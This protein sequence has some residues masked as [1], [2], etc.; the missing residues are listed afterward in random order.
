M[1]DSAI[2]RM[3]PSNDKIFSEL[4]EIVPDLVVLADPAGRLIIFNAACEELTGYRRHEVLGR[5]LM[6]VFVPASCAGVV[7]QRFA[8]PYSPDLRK[9]HENPWMTK[10]GEER[11]ISW[12]CTALKVAGDER[13]YILG[14]GT[15][16]TE[17]RLVEERMRA[18]SRLLE[19]FFESTL[20]CSVLLDRH[21]NFLRVNEAY[22]TACKR[23]AADFIGKNHFDLYPSPARAIFEKVVETRTFFVAHSHPFMFPDRPELGMTYWDWTLVPVLDDN[24]EIEVLLFCLN[25]VTER[26][27]TEAGLREA[28][29]E[30]RDMSRQIVETEERERRRIARELH[31]E[32]GQ[33][34]TAL[35]LVLEGAIGADDVAVRKRQRSAL[36]LSNE[37][38]HSIRQISFDLRPPVLD[39]LG[40]IPALVTMFE[41]FHAL[42]GLEV[43]FRHGGVAER[44]SQDVET[45][46]YRIVQ[47]ALTNVIR[48]AS[49]RLA[50]VSLWS[51]AETVLLRIEDQGAGFEPDAVRVGGG[52][53]LRGMRE[54][55][56]F[57]G[58]SLTVES[59]TGGGTII[60]AELP[61]QSGAWRA[62][63]EPLTS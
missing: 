27:R 48:H 7:G 4:L 16:V 24:G 21:F 6:E 22:A 3:L 13:P 18:Q 58:G 39:D 37:L 32:I 5:D 19:M 35:K 15:D 61:R 11:L 60:M 44:L 2:L 53:G 52:N 31:D 56:R 42:A 45:V 9:P 29:A 1:D 12:R 55:A 54:R 26:Q 40:L 62:P 57:L 46:A 38:L 20:T 50:S 36:D 8:D 14:I 30:L 17:K 47:E 10:S 34:L 59:S 41:R 25:D 28:L 43:S 23:P 63:T 51:N 49:L 33:G